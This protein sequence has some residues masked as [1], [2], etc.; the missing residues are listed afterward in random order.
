[1]SPAAARENTQLLTLFILEIFCQGE[2]I[3]QKVSDTLKHVTKSF[4]PTANNLSTHQF[5][6]MH[7]LRVCIKSITL[8]YLIDGMALMNL[9]ML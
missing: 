8:H 6:F 7:T 2:Y 4:V 1:M 9:F 5:Y 3:H